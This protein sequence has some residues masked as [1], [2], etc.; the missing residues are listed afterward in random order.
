MNAIVLTFNTWVIQHKQELKRQLD[1]FITYK[2]IYIYASFLHI[3]TK[4][5]H[6]Y[7][8][9]TTTTT[10]SYNNYYC[11]YTA[12]YY[13]SR[14]HLTTGVAAAL[15]I[16]IIVALAASLDVVLAVVALVAVVATLL[17]LLLRL[18]EALLV[19]V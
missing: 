13:L 2:Y 16:S 7:T 11:C 3:P 14:W 1:N 10:L 12:L 18:L 6:F 17:V 8:Y 9:L 4:D 19:V 5:L 15:A